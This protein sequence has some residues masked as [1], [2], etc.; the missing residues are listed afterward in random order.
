MFLMPR[1]PPHGPVSCAVLP[2][3][4]GAIGVLEL[5]RPERLNAL[6]H[7]MILALQKQLDCWATDDR[8]ALVLLA[9]NGERG[10]CAGG[11]IRD[12]L[13]Y[14]DTSLTPT[15][16]ATFF[17]VEYRLDFSLHHY[18]KPLICWG[19]GLVLGGGMGIL[20]AC[21]YRLGTP[22]LKM[23]MP[24]TAIGLFPDA[25]AT[26]F[27][28]RLP[29]GIGQFLGLTGASLNI[30]DALRLGLVDHAVAA[31]GRASLLEL[32]QSTHWGASAEANDNLLYRLLQ[33]FADDQPCDLPDGPLAECEQTISALCAEGTAATLVQRILASPELSP[34]WR[35]AQQSLAGACPAS[36]MVFMALLKRGRQMTFAD[37]FRM[38]LGVATQCI[39]HGE[40][41]EGVRAKLIERDREPAWR[42]PSVR[43]VPADYIAEL[44]A[45]PWTAQEHPLRD[46]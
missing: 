40:F 22:D 17:S 6:T 2:C 42:Y 38:E 4:S 37:I 8:I 45:S 28:N 12:L 29:E 18:P 20:Q 31:S 24:E 23:G 34:W 7:E 1:I 32:L 19:H 44:M 43:T 46:L 39:R 3:A 16:S 5:N 25:G 41:S 14:A 21:R 9:G 30:S 11:D 13:Q 36:V 27:L 10:F 26:W 35:T 33:S 15:D